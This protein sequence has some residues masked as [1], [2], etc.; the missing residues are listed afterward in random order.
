M[1][2]KD[3]VAVVT[4][5]GKGIGKAIALAFAK[6]GADVVIAA[7]TEA[8]L[9][10]VAAEIKAL[11]R[12]SLAVVAD[13][14]DFSQPQ[15]LVEKTLKQF[16]KI[17]ILVNNSGAEGPIMT[18]SEMDLERWNE[19][20]AVNLTGAMLCSRYALEKSMIPRKS[21]S[22]INLTSAAGRTGL[23]MRA[24]YSSSKFALI[25]F[26]QSLARE[27]GK[28]GIRVNAIAPGAVEGE[29]IDRVFK[30]SAKNQG[31]TYEQVVAGSNARAA[32]GRMVKPEEVAALAI[33]LAS[34]QSSAITGQ[35][36]NIDAGANFN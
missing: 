25:G 22:V 35:T 7:R 4:G 15:K 21:G 13:L 11:G 36:I 20:L 12:K 1:Q 10:E 23:P 24:A 28:Y 18:V 14:S 30:I 34:G 16:G 6:E 2:F 32:L 5:G 8:A 9:K 17:D 33:F 3:K 31:I 27:V 26:T 29:R 19:L